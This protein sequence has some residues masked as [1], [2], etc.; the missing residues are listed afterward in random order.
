MRYV[1]DSMFLW[2]NLI[3]VN[4]LIIIQLLNGWL[5][6]ILIFL[7]V[8]IEVIELI[9]NT[10]ERILNLI[11]ELFAHFIV[12]SCCLD[13]LLIINVK[14]GWF[15]LNF[16]IS[17][18]SCLIYFWEHVGLFLV[19][20]WLLAIWINSLIQPQSWLLRINW[21]LCSKSWHVISHFEKLGDFL[22]WIWVDHPVIIFFDFY[23]LSPQWI[24]LQRLMGLI[25]LWDH[26]VANATKPFALIRY[27]FRHGYVALEQLVELLTSPVVYLDCFVIPSRVCKAFGNHCLFVSTYG[28]YLFVVGWLSLNNRYLL[29]LLRWKH[30]DLLFLAMDNLVT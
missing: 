18:I 2:I 26:M 28:I 10:F 4:L 22:V 29:V 8:L 27:I 17:S 25:H 24:R 3:W 13:H 16:Y 23:T 30:L 19:L 1:A 5:Q 14:G 11:I 6:Y 15:V 20:G 7:Q 21:R 9:V 12:L